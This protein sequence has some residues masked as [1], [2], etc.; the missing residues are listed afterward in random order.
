MLGR[1]GRPWAPAPSDGRFEEADMTE[2][3]EHVDQPQARG[4]RVVVGVDGSA[5]ARGAL[6]FALEDAVRRGVPVGAVIAHRPPRGW[7][8]FGAIGEVSYARAEAGAGARGGEGI[9]EG[10]PGTPGT[11]P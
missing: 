10:A 7:E 1:T 2:Q 9:A 3:A 8:D 4:P 5:G 11:H 6:R